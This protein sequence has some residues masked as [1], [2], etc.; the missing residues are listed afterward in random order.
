MISP[1]GRRNARSRGGTMPS[2]KPT[3][4]KKSEQVSFKVTAAVAQNIEKALREEDLP[5]ADFVRKVF[6]WGLEQFEV[7]G[8]LRTLRRMALPDDLIERTR[9][10]EREARRQNRALLMRKKAKG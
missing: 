6:L 8:S 3:K 1:A 2:K 9:E 7:V 4:I 10:E 5:L